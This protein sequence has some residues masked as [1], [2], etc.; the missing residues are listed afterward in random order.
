M[1]RVS[2]SRRYCGKWQWLN[3]QTGELVPWY[4]D[5]WD[6]PRCGLIKAKKLAKA[7]AKE[8]RKHELKSLITLTLP[9]RYHNNAFQTGDR[10][11]K[12]G[13]KRLA[14]QWRDEDGYLEYIWVEERHKSGT[15]HLHILSNHESSRHRLVEQ[16]REAGLGY[17][18]DIRP[19]L[20]D[21]GYFYVAKYLGKGEKQLPV[22]V[23]R[24]GTSRGIVLREPSASEDTWRIYVSEETLRELYPHRDWSRRRD[25]TESPIHLIER[26]R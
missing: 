11:L 13:W 24:Y 1:K 2:R 3:E 15:P 12:A 20:D 7:I 19:I 18:A 5:S 17:I 23:R 4:C 6:C 26:E 25:L 16:A 21:G 22:G 8:A 10:A 14:R 9:S